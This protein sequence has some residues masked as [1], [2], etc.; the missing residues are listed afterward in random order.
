MRHACRNM[1]TSRT[2]HARTSSA[3]CRTTN[4][5]TRG[6]EH[7]APNTRLPATTRPRRR[8]TRRG[9]GAAP[10]CP[11]P[12][13]TVCPA[14]TRAPGLALAQSLC[15]GQ[16]RGPIH[17][18]ALSL[19][20]GSDTPGTTGGRL[21]SST[22][23][24]SSLRCPFRT[25]PSHRCRAPPS[26]PNHGSAPSLSVLMRRAQFAAAFIAAAPITPV[27]RP[28]SVDAGT[29]S[30]HFHV[31]SSVPSQAFSPLPRPRPEA[32]WTPAPAPIPK[33]LDWWA[34][35]LRR[36]TLYELMSPF[37]GV[38]V[39]CSHTQIVSATWRAR[40]GGGSF[41]V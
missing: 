26:G 28:R 6:C 39:L 14:P 13:P 32:Q 19:C 33:L 18:S 34:I 36:C 30:T 29:P 10:R 22:P 41:L 8:H 31:H 20:L 5:R 38:I 16:S 2:G 21:H 15:P 37:Q 40:E 24:Q 4:S 1:S 9:Q 27:P 11:P 3:L 7:A 35:C 12:V 25:L 17:S 23:S